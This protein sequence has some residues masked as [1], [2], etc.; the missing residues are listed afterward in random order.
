MKLRKNNNKGKELVKFP[1]FLASFVMPSS[2]TGN[3][4]FKP[5]CSTKREAQC[6]LGEMISKDNEHLASF[7]Q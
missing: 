7:E 6:T 4:T 5:T 1:N 2:E 3:K